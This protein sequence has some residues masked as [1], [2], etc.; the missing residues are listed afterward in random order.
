[1]LRLWALKTRRMKTRAHIDARSECQTRH[2]YRAGALRHCSRTQS[3]TAEAAA[4]RGV[5]K[6]TG[7]LECSPHLKTPSTRRSGANNG[8]TARAALR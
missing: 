2:S 5:L 1:M 8:P 4:A 7:E 3:V 6:T